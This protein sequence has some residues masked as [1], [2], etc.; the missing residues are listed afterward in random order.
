MSW[1]PERIRD[2]R[3]R[4]GESQ[5]VFCQRLGVV[6]GTL[7]SWEQ[8]R[9]EPTGSAL[10]LLGRLEEDLIEGKIRELQSA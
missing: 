2:L 7:R 3:R 5:P 8:G 9:G 1:T 4:Y 10:V 6:C